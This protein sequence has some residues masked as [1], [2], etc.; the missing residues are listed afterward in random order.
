MNRVAAEPAGPLPPGH[1]TRVSSPKWGKS[2]IAAVA[3]AGTNVAIQVQAAEP[4]GGGPIHAFLRPVPG[5]EKAP[6]E[7]QPESKPEPPK[8][9]TRS[10]GEVSEQNK[11]YDRA[12]PDY[13]TLQKANESLAGFPVDR[14]GYVDWMKALATGAIKPLAD[15]HGR[16]PI[17]PM[18]LDVVM[19]NTKEMP[20]VLFP[21][22]S[23]TLWLDCSNC[24]P[25]IFEPKTGANPISMGEI[26]R[27]RYCGVCHD[28]VAFITFFSCDRCHSVPNPAAAGQP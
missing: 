18:D 9:A 1:L 3:L 27:G 7:P 10:G 28:R 5:Q 2:L 4:P 21:H 25:A 15:L 14:Q 22:R 23:H 6:A 8:P 12:N 26:F 17:Q 11:F 19:K 13:A 24:H 16:H 20:H